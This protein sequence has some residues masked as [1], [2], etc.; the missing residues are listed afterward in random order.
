MGCWPLCGQR[1]LKTTA[2]KNTIKHGVLLFLLCF[3]WLVYQNK[4]TKKPINRKTAT[5]K[6]QNNT[7]QPTTTA[8]TTTTAATTTTAT[9]T[10]T[11]Q[12]Q[13]QQTKEQQTKRTTDQKNNNFFFSLLV[14]ARENWA[15]EEKDAQRAKQIKKET[16]KK[17]ER[18]DL[19]LVL[20]CWPFC[21]QSPVKKRKFAKY[22]EKASIRPQKMR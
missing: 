4:K 15:R 2:Q 8:S 21:V 3:L 12:Q 10:T 1:P 17:E 13:Q 16:Q 22:K 20:G 14:L 5:N 18:L 19:F 9:T 11:Q 6:Q 7:N